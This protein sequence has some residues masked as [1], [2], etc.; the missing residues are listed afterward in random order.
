MGVMVN[1]LYV[2]MCCI[3]NYLRSRR[4]KFWAIYPYPYQ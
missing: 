3:T 2:C 4:A 1:V